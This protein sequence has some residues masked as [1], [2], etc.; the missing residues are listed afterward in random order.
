MK[1]Y[2]LENVKREKCYRCKYRNI[3]GGLKAIARLQCNQVNYDGDPDKQ[4]TSKWGEMS[5]Y[6]ERSIRKRS[7]RQR[8]RNGE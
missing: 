7:Q 8:L 1:K 4:Y 3:C 5:Y 2:T 6:K